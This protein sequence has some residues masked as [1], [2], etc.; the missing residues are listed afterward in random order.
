MQK[1]IFHNKI[2]MKDILQSLCTLLALLAS[3]F[4]FFYTQHIV[5][6]TL[7]PIPCKLFA[8]INTLS[9]WYGIDMVIFPVCIDTYMDW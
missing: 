2:S 4:F 7:S 5:C 3:A 6:V 9:I 8:L 1:Q